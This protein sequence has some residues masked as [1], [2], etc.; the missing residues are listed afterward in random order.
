MFRITEFLGIVHHPV[1]QKLDPFPFS[2]ERVGGTCSFG[3]V[4]AK[5]INKVGS[6]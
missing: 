3:S 5:M 1:F 6:F 2:G 4:R